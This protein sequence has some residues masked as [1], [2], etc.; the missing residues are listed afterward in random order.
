MASKSSEPYLA[1]AWSPP[2]DVPVGAV[3]SPILCVATTYT[4][5][6]DF[7]ES[8]LLPRFLGM[9][10]DDTEGDKSFLVE[11]EEALASTRVA[12]LV[13]ASKADARQSTLRWDQIPVFVPGG[14]QHAKVSLLAWESCARIIVASA[15]ITRSGYRRNRE[16]AGILT[17]FNHED[18]VPRQVLYDAI[19]FLRHITGW[20]RADGAVLNRLLAR[21]DEVRARVG[22][23]TAA[24]VEFTER[25]RPRVHFVGGYPRRSGSNPASVLKQTIDL[26]GNAPAD[27][28]A[29][30]TPF[31]GVP[32]ANHESLVNELLGIHHTANAKGYLI[33]PRLPDAETQTSPARIGLPLTF[34]EG[35]AKAWGSEPDELNMYAV[36][37]MRENEKLSRD[38]HAKAILIANETNQLLLCGSSNFSHHGV[39][40]LYYNIEANLAYVDSTSAPAGK[41]GMWERLPV[42]DNDSVDKP[43]WDHTGVDF[44][45]DELPKE[46]QLPALFQSVT[47]DQV[48][49]TLVFAFDPTA[50][51]PARWCVELP[52]SEGAMNL[53]LVIHNQFLRDTPPTAH[54][55]VLPE[56]FK[57]A[58]LTFLRVLWRDDQNELRIARML[59]H[60]VDI[61]Q[62]IPPAEFSGLTANGIVDCLISGRELADIA[63]SESHDGQNHTPKGK[64]LDPL[65]TVKTDGLLLYKMRRLGFALGA[66]GERLLRVARTG[67]AARYRLELDPL[68]PRQLAAALEK[69]HNPDAPSE[70][71]ALGFALSEIALIVGHAGRRIHEKRQAREPDIRGYF[72]ACA[73]ELLAKAISCHSDAEL[74][75]YTGEVEKRTAAL[76][77]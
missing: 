51:I 24:P 3:G 16:I 46:P 77:M 1:S 5:D 34:A 9:K 25:Q 42:D 12:V 10:Y 75:V 43:Q 55:V 35:W 54:T 63:D 14:V 20:T 23:W 8:D 26:W 41:R 69:E 65:R 33:V 32:D 17:F 37:Y 70:R 74:H 49:S 72:R 45:E 39:G 11:R 76:L 73:D 40:V 60:V 2:Q 28:I 59:V 47:Y 44:G 31:V 50:G 30:M 38:L 6:A 4:F 27:T 18:S 21:L 71:E 22:G 66:L 19:D 56:A 67:D 7:L 36:P 58:H 13:D 52:G 29:V 48:Q 57:L 15:N 68:G 53:E 62:L 61:A 64:D